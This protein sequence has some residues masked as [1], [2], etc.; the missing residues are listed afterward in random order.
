M[1]SL[2]RAFCQQTATSILNGK[3]KTGNLVLVAFSSHKEGSVEFIPMRSLACDF[4]ASIKR[5]KK[6]GKFGICRILKQR[7][8]AQSSSCQCT[9]SP[10]PLL[11]A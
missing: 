7:I 2:A 5:E 1:N 10:E 4:A 8:K 3:K 11:L 6:I 9:D